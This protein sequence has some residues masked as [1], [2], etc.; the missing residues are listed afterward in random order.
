MHN[1]NLREAFLGD[2]INSGAGV[3][4]HRSL[5]TKVLGDEIGLKT[6]IIDDWYDLGHTSGLIK[7][8]NMLFNAR[9]FNSISVD[10]ECG[11]LTKTST[12]V[13]KQEDEAFW[14]VHLP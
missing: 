6:R 12:K 14:Y 4:R 5:L 8:K 3:C 11:L 13:Q 9:C 1:P 7:A 10:T 2:I